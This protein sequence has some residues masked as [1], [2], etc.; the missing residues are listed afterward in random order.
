MSVL[1]ACSSTNKS[2]EKGEMQETMSNTDQTMNRSTG[3][4]DCTTG[5]IVSGADTVDSSTDTTDS[6]A[7]MVDS[8]AGTIDRQ[9]AAANSFPDSLSRIPAEYYQAAD[10]QGKLVDLSYQTWE[11][12]SYAEHTEPLE[13]HAVIYLPYGYTEEKRYNVLYL[14]HGGWSNETSWLGPSQDPGGFKNVLDNAIEKG[15]V[16]P[17]IVVCPTYNNT[18]SEDSSDYGLA[19]QLT[20]N[21]HHELV[22]DL[23][24]AVEGK[25]RTYAEDTSPEG[26]KSSRDHRAFAGFSMGSVTTW[27]TFEYCL[28]YFRYFMPASGSLTTDGEEMAGMV[29]DQ[30]YDW[31]DFFIFGASGTSDFA[32]SSFRTQIMNMSQVSDGTFRLANNEKNGNLWYLE[33]E[34]G[35]HGPVYAEE[36]LYNGLCWIWKN[37]RTQESSTAESGPASF[38]ASSTVRDVVSDPAFGDFGRLLFPVDRNVPDDMTLEEVSSST[39]YVWYNDIDVNETVAIV[40]RLKDDAAAGKQIFYPIYSEEEIESDPSKGDTGLFY[41]RGKPGARFAVMNAGGGFMYVG[42]MQDSFPHALEVSKMGYNCFA[43]IYRPDD[44]YDDLAQA[45]SFIHENADRLQIDPD[46]YSLWGGSA[47]ARMAAALGNADV[48]K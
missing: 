36:Y 21:Y 15:L 45:L 44:P 42:A 4:D 10:K 19:L 31:D 23:M 5:T 41:F 11:S 14:M 13:K 8:S 39:V 38:S 25:Y 17:M 9:P 43:L 7:G 32:R 3:T 2:E 26:L 16:T 37:S 12:F 30:G 18:S 27:H 40:N 35:S 1:T 29:H 34:G 28:D 24:P 48:L 33:Q 22:N 46:G 47:G 20:D 6:S